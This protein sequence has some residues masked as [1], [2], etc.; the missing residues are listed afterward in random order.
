MLQMETEKL[1]LHDNGGATLYD[2]SIIGSLVV[3]L[4]SCKTPEECKGVFKANETNINKETELAALLGREQAQPPQAWIDL[5]SDYSKQHPADS[6]PRSVPNLPAVGRMVSP[7]VHLSPLLSA[8][9]TFHTDIPD[10]PALFPLDVDSCHDLKCEL[11]K[12]FYVH[13]IDYLTNGTLVS[14]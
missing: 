4:R 7:T 9:P 3:A 8:G 5:L 10:P 14:I 13:N 12:T 6:V 11:K 2:S 1:P